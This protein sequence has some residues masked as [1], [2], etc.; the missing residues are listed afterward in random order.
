[1]ARGYADYPDFQPTVFGLLQTAIG[2]FDSDNT[3]IDGLH[4]YRAECQR[5]IGLMLLAPGSRNAGLGT[6]IH[7]AFANYASECGAKQLLSAVL[8]EN[9]ATHRFWSKL[10]YRKV[11]DHPP[12][13]YGF[14]VH[15]STEY[16]KP[17]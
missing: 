1:M 16:E 11:K 3:L 6:Q 10:G 4:H 5:W 17:L 12:K 14:N 15:A 9:T 8:E 7:G 2:V 13:R